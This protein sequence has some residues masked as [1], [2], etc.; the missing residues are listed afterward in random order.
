MFKQVFRVAF[1]TL[2]WKQYKGSIIS[3]LL[4]IAYLFIVSS[5][6]RDY[7]LAAGDE[8]EKITFVYKWLAYLVGVIA[9][10]TFHW[11]RSKFS[12]TLDETSQEN[13]KAQIEKY[14]AMENTSDD[15]FAEIRTREKLRSRADFL[16][17]KEDRD[18]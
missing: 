12:Q 5:I 18:R 15:P 6:H 8:A 17:E 1:I 2:I 9:F 7:L 4:L 11:I 14:R 13:T 3:T 10:C 16:M